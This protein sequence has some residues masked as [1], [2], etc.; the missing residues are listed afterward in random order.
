MWPFKRRVEIVEFCEEFYNSEVFHPDVLAGAVVWDALLKTI[1]DADGTYGSI[2]Q[3]E[4]VRELNAMRVEIFGLAWVHQLGK[5]E[6]IVPE[7][8]FTQRYL[9]SM[10]RNDI[11]EAMADYNRAV[12]ESG[13]QIE[14]RQQARKEVLD[15]WVE[16]GVD[17]WIGERAVNRLGSDKSWEQGV[18]QGMLADTF[19]RRLG[20]ALNT[21][22]SVRLREIISDLYLRCYGAVKSVKVRRGEWP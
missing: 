21:N 13:E 16:A 11:W 6:Y 2:E 22:G 8:L 9:R 12:L 10:N 4:F 18:T 17:L 20:Q 14:R 5:K 15:E 3:P 19:Q 1:V 7:L